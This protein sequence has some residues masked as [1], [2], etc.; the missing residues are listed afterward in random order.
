MHDINN[1]HCLHL[2]KKELKKNKMDGPQNCGVEPKN[3]M[4]FQ[5]S[6]PSHIFLAGQL[7]LE[8]LG[9]YHFEILIPA[10]GKI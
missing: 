8:K 2:K 3:S 4:Y 6:F 5:S 9:F 7:I 1:L 10:F